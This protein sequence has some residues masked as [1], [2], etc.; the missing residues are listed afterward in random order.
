[1]VQDADPYTYPGTN[2]LRNKAGIRDA[3]ALRDFEYEDVNFR[4]EDLRENP[5]QGKFDLAHLKKIHKYLFQGVYEW[6]GEV[7]TRNILKDKTRFCNTH[8]IEGYADII[9]DGL[10]KENNLRGLDKTNFV[11]R[12]AFYFSEW[13]TVHPFRDGNGRSI[14]EFFGQ[15]AREAG[16]EIDQTKIDRNKDRWDRASELS[17]VNNMEPLKQL[18]TE[19]VQPARDVALEKLPRE[20]PRSQ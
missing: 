16:Y 18:L 7:R 3:N 20:V 8:F 14:R 2:V 19:A 13:N 4:V 6:A 1:M 17:F 9:S 11:N 15:L 12:L 10:S 5:I